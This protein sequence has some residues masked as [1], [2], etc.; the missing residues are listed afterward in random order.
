[1]NS[2]KQGLLY[3]SF[4]FLIACNGGEGAT[5]TNDQNATAETEQPMKEKPAAAKT[6]TAALVGYKVGDA[7]KS[8]FSLKNIDGEMVAMGDY[9]EAKGYVIVFTCN[10]CPY[11]IAYEDRLS[12]VPLLLKY[13]DSLRSQRGADSLM[14]NAPFD[15][16]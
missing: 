13:L 4:L 1:M 15:R 3:S 10:H 16:A 11:S 6:E 5:T 9:P 2:L 7:L 14:A 8:D 12:N